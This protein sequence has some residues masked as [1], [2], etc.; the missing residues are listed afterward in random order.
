[1]IVT[2]VLAAGTGSRVGGPKAL[3][4]VDDLPLAALHA[5]RR[6]S[7][8]S[9]RVVLVVRKE[10]AGALAKTGLGATGPRVRVVVSDEP[11]ALGPAGSLR[12]ALVAGAFV[13][14]DRLLITP[15]DVLP[16]SARLTHTL[17]GALDEHEAA[18]PSHGHPIALRASV[19]D[20]A[21]RADPA[22]LRDVLSLLGDRCAVVDVDGAEDFDTPEDL[23]RVAGVANVRFFGEEAP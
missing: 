5:Q 2:V 1:M 22:P 18:R 12:A 7:R 9:D 20:P 19:L 23:A 15:V 13:P 11:E 14:E 8:E 6:L 17:L 21:F 10:V 16:A 4:L 3:L